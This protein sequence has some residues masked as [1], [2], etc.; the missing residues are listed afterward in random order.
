MKPMHRNRAILAGPHDAPAS[1]AAAGT[2]QL[3]I[4][5]GAGDEF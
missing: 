5:W 1:L 3:V 2:A 4:S